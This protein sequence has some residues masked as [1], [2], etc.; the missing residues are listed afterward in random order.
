MDFEKR[1]FQVNT[2]SPLSEKLIK[3][4]SINQIVKIRG[5][6]ISSFCEE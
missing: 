1:A 3:F 2:I 4:I 6:I 5:W